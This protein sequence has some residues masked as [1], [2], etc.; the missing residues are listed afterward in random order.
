MLNHTATS[1]TSLASDDFVCHHCGSLTACDHDII[2][3]HSTTG[4]PLR[5]E[6]LSE[7]EWTRIQSDPDTVDMYVELP[8][9][10]GQEVMNSYGE[11]IGEARLLVEWG[12]VPGS[13][14]RDEHQEEDEE[15]TENLEENYAGD[16][17]TWDLEDLVSP[18]IADAWL[19]MGE[20]DDASL[21]LFPTDVPDTEDETTLICAPK[22]GVYHLNYAGQV[23]LRLFAALYLA[24][25]T[26]VG[27]GEDAALELELISDVNHLEA[28]W[29][30]DQAG[31]QVP[32]LR[33]L[34]RS[35]AEAVRDLLKRRLEGMY[36]PELAVGRLYDICEVST[37]V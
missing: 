18:D 5:L 27:K 35:T 28:T 26:A 36:R 37:E 6:H 20:V 31:E 21:H 24:S 4:I 22:E 13:W 29:A 32:P 8:V 19:S 12:F 25:A 17:V 11:G 30:Q 3:P 33:R 14:P 7:T 9:R 15:E 10:Q 1:H 34:L 23:S 2:H 16:G